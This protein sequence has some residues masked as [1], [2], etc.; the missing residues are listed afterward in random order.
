M[1]FFFLRNRHL[2]FKAG[3]SLKEANS[4][5]I[6]FSSL[7]LFGFKSLSTHEKLLLNDDG[8][9]IVD[10]KHDE[11]EEGNHYGKAGDDER[12]QNERM[13]M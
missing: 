4:R 12:D 2:T 13:L 9:E 7:V 10:F 6:N 5:I 8:V 11:V 1:L 3:P